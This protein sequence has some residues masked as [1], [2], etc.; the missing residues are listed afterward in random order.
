MWHSTIFGPYFVVGAIFSG[1]A[2]LL[3]AMAIIRKLL[4]LE[5]YLLPL[6]FDNLGKLL[7]TMSLLW[8]YFTFTEYLTTWYA[9]YSAE[10][11]VFWSK[12]SGS[13][14]PIFWAMVSCNFLIPFPLLAIK[15][16]RTIGGVFAA[17]LLIL[18]GMWLERFLIVVPTLTNTYLPYNHGWY[19]PSWVEVSIAVGS[20][21]I[22]A[23]LYFLFA[24]FS[25][26]I[27][28]WEVKEGQRV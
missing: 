25:P 1:I 7:L 24:K 3:V 9:N 18:V 12:I 13:Y 11:Q 6:H 14:A 2:A 4:H 10:M 22:F 5:K 15:R 17:S 21:A 20:F 28:V 26:I 27:S 19:R 16:L 8:F 23:L